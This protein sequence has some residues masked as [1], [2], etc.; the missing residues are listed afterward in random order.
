MHTYLSNKSYQL[1]N[2]CCSHYCYWCYWSGPFGVL[3][4]PV[5][6]VRPWCWQWQLPSYSGVHLRGGEFR[7]WPPAGGRYSAVPEPGDCHSWR[8][9]CS[10]RGWTVWTRPSSSRTAVPPWWWSARVR[11]WRWRCCAYGGGAISSNSSTRIVCCSGWRLCSK[12]CWFVS[13]EAMASISG[14]RTAK[15]WFLLPDLPGSV[16]LGRRT[17]HWWRRWRARTA[18]ARRSVELQTRTMRWTA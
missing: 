10:S 1:V 9:G 13:V 11:C 8:S 5:L 17:D 7:R 12:F 14:W 4:D 3:P 6:P 18:T 15:E 16:G 2:C